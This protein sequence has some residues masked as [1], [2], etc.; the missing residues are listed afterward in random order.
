MR[1]VT[2]MNESCEC[3]WHELPIRCVNGFSI[4]WHDMSLKT[5]GN[6]YI[7]PKPFNHYM[8]K[9]IYNAENMSLTSAL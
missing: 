6:I 7:K 8:S 2:Y 3:S 9:H 1:H 5:Y 4:L